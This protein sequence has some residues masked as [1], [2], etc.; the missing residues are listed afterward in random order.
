MDRQRAIHSVRH[1]A[2]EVRKVTW[3]NWDKLGQIGTNVPGQNSRK[4]GQDR[5]PPLGK[6]CPI[7]PR[8]D[9]G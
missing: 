6:G 1:D 5:T 2:Q 8:P 4:L 3:D 7:V 9:A